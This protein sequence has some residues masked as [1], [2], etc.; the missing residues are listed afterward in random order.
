MNIRAG[1]AFEPAKPF[2]FT[3]QHDQYGWQQQADG[4]WF[5]GLFVMSGRIKDDGNYRLKSALRQ[6]V[7]KFGP[8]VRLSPS[9]NI[10]LC[11]FTADQREAVTAIFAEHGVPVENQATI[12]RRA[13]MA[14]PALPTCGLSLSESERFLP[15]LLDRIEGLLGELGLGDEE[16]V[17]RMTGCPNGC[18]R[19][20]MAEIGFVGKAP[21]RY[22]LW[23]GGNESSTR[24]N[25]IYKDV[26]KDAEIIPELKSLFERWRAT[27]LGSERF[28]DWSARVVWPELATPAAT[29]AQSAVAAVPA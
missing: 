15:G 12:I 25:K 8:E 27:R 18:A 2:Q 28:G 11:N 26:V 24:I 7:E 9:Q 14:C 29:P 6:V 1:F 21:G 10:I 13:S 16:I 19:P 17:I 3:S 5:L 23:I 4:R 22:Q 20:Y